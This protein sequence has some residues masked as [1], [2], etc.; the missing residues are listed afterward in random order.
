MRK[1]N[2][3]SK[4]SS[5][6]RSPGW[7]PEGSSAIEV[8]R[9][10]LD[11]YQRDFTRS[12]SVAKHRASR[13]VVWTSV[14]SGLTAVVG[15]VISFTGFAWLGILT[16]AFSGFVAVLTTW[17]S[18]FRHKEL[19]AQRSGIL[20]ELQLMQRDYSMALATG[21]EPDVVAGV[22][23]ARL[24]SVLSR[25]LSSWLEGRERSEK[26]HSPVHKRECDS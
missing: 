16:A 21:E 17:D 10:H 19:W 8:Y 3:E 1:K 11:F 18:H 5:G 25:D 12:R 22:G 24:S 9:F 2:E 4:Q 20:H 15:A 14:F 23:M 6:Q 13:V 26:P 7:A